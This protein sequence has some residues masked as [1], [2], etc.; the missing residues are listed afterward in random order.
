MDLPRPVRGVFVGGHAEEVLDL[1]ADEQVPALRRVPAVRDHRRLGDEGAETLVG[2]QSSLGLLPRASGAPY[3]DDGDPCE[4]EH[5]EADQLVAALHPA[6]QRL[7]PVIDIEREAKQEQHGNR[8]D[9]KED[10]AAGRIGLARVF[11]L[12]FGHVPRHIGAT[13]G[14]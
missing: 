8:R 5:E 11:R 13:S 12:G 1:W 3:R 4:C 6:E 7:E 14:H 10:V 9:D 2:D